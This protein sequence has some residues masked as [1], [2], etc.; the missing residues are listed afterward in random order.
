MQRF[1]AIV[2]LQKANNEDDLQNIGWLLMMWVARILMV[3][4]GFFI[5]ICARGSRP[6][7]LRNWAGVVYHQEI[8]EEMA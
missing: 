5:T 6:K 3:R 2:Q 1:I 8:G 4:L 7:F